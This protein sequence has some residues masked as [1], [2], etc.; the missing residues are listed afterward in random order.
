[1]R[2]L[3]RVDSTN[4]N[5]KG[6]ILQGRIDECGLRVYQ[7]NNGGGKSAIYYQS[8]LVK[9]VFHPF[10]EDL[11]G[12]EWREVKDYPEYKVSNY[13]RV[14]RDKK[15]GKYGDLHYEILIKQQLNQKGYYSIS[16]SKDGKIKKRLVHVLVAEVFVEN[17]DPIHKKEVDHI[18]TNPINNNVT[19]LR[20]CTRKENQNNPLTR[21]HNSESK[22]G[23]PQPERKKRIE[24]FK[25]GVSCGIYDSGKDLEA[26]SLADFGT[27]L[28]RSNVCTV[29]KG[30][31]EHCKGY[32]FKY[33]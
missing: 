16:L 3:D 25:D 30:R 28:N 6:K 23:V 18:D 33:V 8:T 21:K 10:V 26:K 5:L 20:W 9:A 12:E 29:L 27:V 15:I 31:R 32:T 13:G 11:D 4:R 2:S 24:V 1:M 19:N 17:P 7:F 14:K 22:T